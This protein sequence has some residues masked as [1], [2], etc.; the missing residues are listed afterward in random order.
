MAAILLPRLRN[1]FA[2]FL[3]G[4][5][6]DH[7]RLLASPTCVGCGY[8]RVLDSSTRFF[9]EVWRQ[10]L[11]AIAFASPLREC[12]LPDL[13]GSSPYRLGGPASGSTGSLLA[14]SV[15]PSTSWSPSPRHG[16]INPSSIVYAFRPRLRS[17]LTLGGMT[18]P[19]KPWAYGEGDSRHPLAL[20]V[21]A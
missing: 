13:P 3:N 16:N 9:S 20:L 11:M 5:Y 4:G 18:C 21:P 7:L 14:S 19:R 10:P 8:G 17:R 1:H 2:E 12:E 6:L 15:T